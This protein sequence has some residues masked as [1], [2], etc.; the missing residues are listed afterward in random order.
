MR[1]GVDLDN[2]II[3]YDALFHALAL[4]RGWIAPARP[5]RPVRKDAVRRAV[6]LLPDGDEKWQAL[7]A[8]AYGPRLA[9][10]ALFPGGTP[11]GSLWARQPKKAASRPENT[12]SIGI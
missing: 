12:P 8:E 9:S 1:I 2:T 4:E 5:A 6:R 7:Q 10:A 11:G 3:C